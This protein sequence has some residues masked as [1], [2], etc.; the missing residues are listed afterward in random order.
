MNLRQRA[1]NVRKVYQE[2]PRPFWV[3]ILATFIDRLGGFLLFPFF[4]LYITDHFDVGLT[5]VG[6]LFAI[7]SV[8]S[9]VGSLASGVLTDRF[10]RKWMLLFGLVTSALSSLA[11]GF[12]DSLQVFYILAGL[13]G[14]LSNTG[15]PAQQAMVADL[16]PEEKQG[17]GYG[18]VRVAFNVSAAIGPAIGGLLA[19]RSFL[20]LFIADAVTSLITAGIV[21]FALPETKPQ[22]SPEGSEEQDQAKAQSGGGYGRVL[23]DYSFLFFVFL[24]ILIVC[25]Y[26]QMNSTLPV[27]LHDYHGVSA[28]GYGLLLSINAL[29]VVFMQFWIS[30]RIARYSPMLMVALGAALY[31]VGFFMFGITSTYL[32]FVLAV[33]IIT[34]GEMLSAPTS[35]ALVARF[36]PEDMRGR[37]MAIFGMSWALPA[38]FAPLAAGFIIDNY[39]PNWVWYLCGV[40]SAVA[41]LGLLL[42]DARSGDRLRTEEL[43]EPVEVEA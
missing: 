30:R 28:Q 15:G 16:L 6:I 34:V 5:E 2:Y 43:P 36:S 33:V 22:A 14:L 40:I 39:N 32:A 11:M 1:S 17:E 7:F 38:T 20:G 18:L 24:G 12:V 13:V 29:M 9:I 41:V 26:I 8:A 27:Y 21:Y 35:Q 23:R 37:Y 10:G 42:L 31:G 25:I 4:S 3:L 19:T